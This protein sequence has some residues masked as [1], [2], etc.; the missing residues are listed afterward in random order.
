MQ[1]RRSRVH[2]GRRVGDG[3]VV[4]KGAGHGVGDYSDYS[5]Y[6]RMNQYCKIL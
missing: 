3:H 1:A 5:G 4:W 6:R 2:R